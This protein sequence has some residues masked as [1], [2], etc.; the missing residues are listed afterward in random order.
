MTV[1]LITGPPA[2]G[3]STVSRL[4][5]QGRPRC[6]LIDVD[7]I[8]DT[9][10]VT[11]AVLP[12]PDWPPELV[13]QLSAARQAAH[14][15]ARAY[16]AIGF[17]VVID[18]FLDTHSLLAEYDELADLDPV[19][20]VLL[21]DTAAARARNRERGVGGSYIDE[22]IA[23]VYEHLPTTEE[24]QHRGWVV[25][26]TTEESADESRKRILALSPEVGE[27]GAD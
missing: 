27:E 21:P 22:G 23:H 24:L 2:V 6:V 14:G 3:K 4:L 17:D 19:R 10:V 1:F 5:A 25:L 11:G 8:R 13:A 12:S 20:I 18:D 26:D 9:M 7:R 16:A 15:I